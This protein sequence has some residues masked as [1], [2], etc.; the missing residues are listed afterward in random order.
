ME[1]KRH[2]REILEGSEYGPHEGDTAQE[3]MEYH[4]EQAS[5]HPQGKSRKRMMAEHGGL[6]VKGAY[7]FGIPTKQGAQDHVEEYHGK[8]SWRMKILEFL[9]Q[10]RISF[11][12][13]SLM[14]LDVIILF[15]EL[16]LMTQYPMCTI[17]ERDCISCCPADASHNDTNHGI[18]RFLAGDGDHHDGVCDSGLEPDYETGGC[19]SHKWGAIHN[20]EKALFAITIAILSTFFV[21]LNME[22]IALRPAI[23]FRQFFYALD[24]TIVTVSL[25]LELTLHFLHEDSLAALFGLFIFARIWRFIRIGHGLV[26]VTSEYTHQK[27]DKLLEYTAALEEAAKQC[28]VQLPKCPHSVRK[29]LKEQS[30]SMSHHS[31]HHTS[32]RAKSPDTDSAES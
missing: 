27:Y 25:V 17:I 15:L 12:L 29:A 31:S 9:H 24:Y 23:F 19:D 1:P 8:T 26:E 32:D 28:E 5:H 7:N 6:S 11:I 18:E 2:N 20:A 14:L 16:F 30:S 3:I 21:E 10:P 13:M 22:M 4:D